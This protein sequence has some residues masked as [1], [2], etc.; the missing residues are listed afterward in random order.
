MHSKYNNFYAQKI[1]NFAIFSFRL[2]IIFFPCLII[3]NHFAQSH[4]IF[5]NFCYMTGYCNA[6]RLMWCNL[7][8]VVF[9]TIKG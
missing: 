5:A 7:Y 4:S 8:Y 6:Q 3:S 2:P 9:E 1:K